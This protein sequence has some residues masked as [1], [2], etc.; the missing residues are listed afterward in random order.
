MKILSIILGFI[1][2]GLA[3]GYI[4]LRDKD[5]VENDYQEYV[6]G[7]EIF[8]SVNGQMKYLDIG[9][10]QTILLIHGVP[11]NSWMYRNL[12]TELAGN[13]YRVIAPDLIGFG[14][15]SR[16]AQYQM[17]D[18][19]IQAE[20]LF[21]L[22]ESL[23]IDSWEQVT[24]DMGGIIS[25]HMI[26]E[27]PEKISHMYVLNTI[28]YKETFNPP[29]DF[30]YSNPL[31]RWVLSLHA[32]P[33]IGKLIV[34]NMIN[35]GTQDINFSPPERAGYWFPLRKGAMSLVHFFTRT[36]DIKENLDTYRSWFVDSGVSV[37]VLWGENDPF[38]DSSSAELLKNEMN[39]D[40][41]EVV[42]LK[43]TK[44][45]VAEE[46]YLEIANFIINHE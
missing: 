42:I 34:N 38:L 28:L 18:F 6:K 22:M 30:S 1:I 26:K 8:D 40:E 4:V 43:N 5:G 23:D 44:H 13:G 25:W 20:T 29:A 33:Y 39:L 15:S 16:P 45:L 32:H 46:A 35:T 12:A 2:L 7:L 14:A 31:H 27:Q 10:G 21:G 19:D 24:H 17:H 9:E 3:I 11:T 36:K 37:S 41:D